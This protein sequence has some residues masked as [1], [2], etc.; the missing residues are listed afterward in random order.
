MENLRSGE[1]NDSHWIPF[2]FF[3][4]SSVTIP[5]LKCLGLESSSSSS[6]DS[7][8][9]SH[10]EEEDDMERKEDE[11]NDD[12]TVEITERRLQKSKPKPKPKPSSGKGGKINQA[13]Y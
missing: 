4:R 13:S 3:D 5:L 11:E 9:S 7:L 12:T 2:M 10:S 8:L 1:E 6:S